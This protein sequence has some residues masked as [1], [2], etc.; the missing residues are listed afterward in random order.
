MFGV[1]FLPSQLVQELHQLRRQLHKVVS[2]FVKLRKATTS[3][4]T[5]ACPSVR[6]SVIMKQPHW[7]HC[8]Y[9]LHGARVLL[10]KLTGLQL[11]KKFPTFHGS[12]RFITALTNVVNTFFFI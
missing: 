2:A 3:F 5:S 6:P 11:V 10:E 4:V 9:L 1:R 12:R 7:T 8:H